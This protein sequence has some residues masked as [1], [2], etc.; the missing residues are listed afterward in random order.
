MDSGWLLWT[1]LSE[2]TLW[3]TQPPDTPLHIT[4]PPESRPLSDILLDN[5]DGS[6][7]YVFEAIPAL[8]RLKEWFTSEYD[9]LLHAEFNSMLLDALLI[10]RAAETILRMK[11]RFQTLPATSAATTIDLDADPPVVTSMAAPSASSSA[12]AATTADVAAPAAEEPLTW[13]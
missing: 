7:V 6:A 3:P 2:R 10:F 9:V 11:Q 4:F 5:F 1:Q 12:P 8:E 13:Y